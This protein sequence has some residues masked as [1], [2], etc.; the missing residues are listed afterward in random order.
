[1]GRILLHI[2]CTEDTQPERRVQAIE[3]TIKQKAIDLGFF[4]QNEYDIIADI[5]MGICLP[6]YENYTVRIRIGDF[7]INSSAPAESKQGY[8][9]WS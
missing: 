9:R 4:K 8:N 1:M 6:G 5:G 2:E 7:V 3:P